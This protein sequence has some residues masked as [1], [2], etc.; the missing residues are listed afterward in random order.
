MFEVKA[1]AH[2]V[3]AAYQSESHWLPRLAQTACKSGSKV[4]RCVMQTF[5]P[6]LFERIHVTII[7]QT[8]VAIIGGGLAGLHTAHLLH[9]A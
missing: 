3:G 8:Q 4:R 7:T 1:S 9:R 2:T 5:C 6:C